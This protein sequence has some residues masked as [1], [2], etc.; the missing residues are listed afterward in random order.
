MPVITFRRNTSYHTGLLVAAALIYFIILTTTAPKPASLIVISESSA[1]SSPQ[2]PRKIDAFHS[3]ISGSP[4]ATTARRDYT[5]DPYRWAS[6]PLPIL[7]GAIVDMN[8][9]EWVWLVHFSGHADRSKAVWNTWARRFDARVAIVAFGKPISEHLP[10]HTVAVNFVG[11]DAWAKTRN[12]FR[13]ARRMYP[14][15]V[16]FSKFDDDTYVY[17]KNLH[18][19][20]FVDD[21]NQRIKYGGYPLRAEDVVFASG[22]AGYSVHTDALAVI[23]RCDEQGL[24]QYEDVAMRKCLGIDPVDLVGTHPHHP[25]QMLRWDKE[26]HPS[27]HIRREEPDASYTTPLTYHYV[28]ADEMERMHDD[29]HV[30]GSPSQRR[31]R[32]LPKVIHQF[33]VGSRRPPTFAIES[34]CDMHTRWMHYLWD[35]TMIK[36]KFP[37]SQLVNQAEY[38]RPN[39]ELNLLSDI[40]RYEFLMQYGGVYIDA[41]TQCLQPLDFLWRDLY[42]S[43]DSNVKDGACVYE[44]EEHASNV[45]G[46]KLVATGVLAMHPFAPTTMLLV[47]YLSKTDWSRAAWISAGPLFATKLFA[48]LNSPMTYLPS[49]L[50]YPFHHT[51]TRPSSVDEVHRILRDKEALT[52]QLWSTTHNAYPSDKS[53]DT[54]AAILASMQNAE[55][56]TLNAGEAVSSNLQRLLDEYAMFHLRSLS[57]VNRKRPRW[58]VVPTEPAAGM[59]NRAMNLASALLLAIATHR[60][61]LFDWDH[62][63]A[64][65]WYAE[66][67]EQIGHSGYSETFGS[68]RIM[69]SYTKA[70]QYYGWSDADAK[71]GAINIDWRHRDFLDNLRNMDMD[72]AYPQSVVFI[73]RF[74][75]WAPLLLANPSYHSL[76]ASTSRQEAFATLFRFLFPLKPADAQVVENK[77]RCGWFVQI[78]RKWER[79]TASLS[80]FV[81][82]A[83]SHGYDSKSSNQNQRVSYLLSDTS[84]SPQD[85]GLIPVD[86]DDGVYCRDGSPDCDRNTLR[87]MYTLSKCTEGAILTATSTFGACIAGLGRVPRLARVTAS[88]SC[89]GLTTSDPALDV[90]V[91]E[92]QQPELV[93]AMQS[94]R[95]QV[96]A[97]FVYLMYGSSRES[98]AELRR[99]LAQLHSHFNQ[100]SN[101][102]Y[103]L[104]LF[105]DDVTQWEW[106]QAETSVRVHLIE[107]GA[108][109][110]VIPS[111]T[112]QAG[113]YPD[114][115][116]LRS[117][118]DHRGF[119]LSYRQMSRYAAGY[120]L[121]H[122]YLERFDYVIKIDGDTHTTGKWQKDPFAE[123]F[124]NEVK[125]GFWISYSDTPDVTDNLFETFTSYLQEYGLKMKHSELIVDGN[126]NYR[127]TTFYGCFLLAEP[128]FFRRPEYLHL[129]RYFDQRHGWFR[130]RWD[131]QKIY[132]FYVA[133][134]L[135]K[136]EVEFM[137]YVSI[138]H[139]KWATHAQRI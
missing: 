26:G 45:E 111:A 8:Q 6:P 79:K 16:Y 91:L 4:L 10:S 72:R 20:L 126:G 77:P 37:S 69:F 3:M 31:T 64:R 19:R 78:R 28:N 89:Q 55:A 120:L 117:S 59:C 21:T 41:D 139:Q 130:H 27:D 92:S 132:A 74:D 101:R 52:D 63:P 113:G 110:W 86:K 25:W 112:I 129:F 88:G 134:Y 70:L 50:F 122:P 30:I 102:H 75:W 106:F 51:D 133:L 68:P 9:I 100:D 13:E 46:Y 42:S 18:R 108:E 85:S 83:T 57:P 43:P 54:P 71:N 121:N 80:Q 12:V 82:C 47:K 81:D 32:G 125:F 11:N 96:S 76:F 109:D 35:D 118:P 137:D 15:A 58:I 97:A 2:S 119:P 34:C 104:V 62:V 115:F 103:P 22:G 66:Q 128:A 23:E 124:A 38:S 56:E 49:R 94:E 29:W 99:S 44:S 93:Q 98:V 65:Q 116:R 95:R 123:A 36:A 1:S 60:T 5:E 53:P 39:Q 61:L 67:T 17:S 90:G 33:W 105:V 73:Q 24:S 136:S 40:A 114:M 14:R 84:E 7:N 48:Q 127:R 135:D 87:T 131:E 107:V 138:E